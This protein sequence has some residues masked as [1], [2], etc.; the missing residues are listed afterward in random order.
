[1]TATPRY[2]GQV[3]FAASTNAQGQYHIDKLPIGSYVLSIY[4]DYLKNSG[5]TTS[6]PPTLTAGVQ[7]SKDSQNTNFVLG[8]G[9]SPGPGPGPGPGP[10]PGTG[11]Q[12]FQPGLVLLSV[13]YDYPN[14]DAA[15]LLGLQ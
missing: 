4:A 11:L 3:D 12:S 13:P 10:Q 6:T 1:L 5:Y 8:G 14:D 2:V 15:S 9:G 7:A